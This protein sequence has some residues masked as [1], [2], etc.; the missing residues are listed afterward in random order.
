MP[1]LMHVCNPYC[2]RC[3]PPKEPLLTCTACGTDND[4][5]LGEYGV[6]KACGAPLP[7]RTLPEPIMCLRI[8]EMCAKPCGLGK[9]EPRVKT[10]KCSYHTPMS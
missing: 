8:N 6:C 3:K 7:E 4:P 5:E 10:A 9:V 1:G 2:G